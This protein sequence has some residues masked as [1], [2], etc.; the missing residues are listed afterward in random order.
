MGLFDF[1]RNAGS[2][3]FGGGEKEPEPPPAGTNDEEVLRRFQETRGRQAAARLT[4]A[5]ADLGLEVEGLEITVLGEVATVRGTAPNQETREK[6]ILVVGN[7]NGISQVDDQLEVDDSQPE[8]VFHTVE[9]GDTLSAI[10]K[11]HYGN[12]MKYPVIFEANKPM[13]S[14]PDKIYPGQVLRIPALAD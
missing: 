8:A 7:H 13:L 4:K 1:V 2:A 5:V 12:A 11:K 9:R 3:I 6:V 14:D 10:A